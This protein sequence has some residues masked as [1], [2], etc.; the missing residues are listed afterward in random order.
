[1]THTLII[2]GCPISTKVIPDWTQSD[3]RLQVN[4]CY[5]ISMDHYICDLVSNCVCDKDYLLVK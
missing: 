4:A 3:R 2:L 1:M 5:N